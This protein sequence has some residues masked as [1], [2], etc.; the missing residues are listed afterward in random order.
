MLIE[1]LNEF[2]AQ[3]QLENDE[4]W[5]TEIIQDSRGYYSNEAKDF[6]ARLLE[7]KRNNQSAFDTFISYC[8]RREDALK[9]ARGFGPL[10][11]DYHIFPDKMC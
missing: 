1:H 10:K 4:F 5:M 8:Q 11:D 7:F 9:L 6:T 3:E 2:N